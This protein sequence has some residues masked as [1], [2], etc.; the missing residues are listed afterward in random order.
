MDDISTS[1]PVRLPVWWARR[2]SVGPHPD[3]PGV[4]GRYI[5]VRHA[6]KFGRFEKLLAKIFRAPAELRRPLDDMNSLVWELCNG[7]RTFLEICE[8]LDTTFDERI[9]PVE[10]RT[11][12]SLSR[13]VHLGYIGLLPEPFD[14]RWSIAPGIDPSGRLDPPNEKLGLDW[15][16]L[17]GDELGESE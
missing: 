17:E 9:A 13:M 15:S 8:I 3:L 14:N 5:V 7:Q 11:T 1:Y 12:A 6:K 4:T 16:T 10:E 2:G